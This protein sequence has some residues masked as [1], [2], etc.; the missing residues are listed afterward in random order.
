M[1]WTSQ[2]LHDDRRRLLRRRP[3]HHHHLIVIVITRLDPTKSTPWAC[4]GNWIRLD[5]PSK[6]LSTLW[7]LFFSWASNF[8]AEW[9][10]SL[11]FCK[12]RPECGGA[13]QTKQLAWTMTIVIG[14]HR[15]LCNIL[16]REAMIEN[17]KSKIAKLRKSRIPPATCPTSCYCAPPTPWDLAGLCWCSGSGTVF[18]KNCHQGAQSFSA[19]P[20]DAQV[21]KK[22]SSR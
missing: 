8:F 3:H 15:D 10:P 20:L 2:V 4:I 19:M 1:N 5:G 13:M 18:A 9:F 17:Q 6:F 22:V 7:L 11:V 12:E 14:I 21:F 16:T